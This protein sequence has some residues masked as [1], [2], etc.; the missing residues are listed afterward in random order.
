MQDVIN[1]GL[2]GYGNAAKVFHAPVIQAVQGLSLKKVVERRKKESSERY[3]WVDVVGDVTTLLLDESIELV[4]IATPNNTHFELARQALLS[5]KHVVVD[6][7]LTIT[8]EQAHQLIGLARQQKRV[9]SVF[10]NRRWDGDF[11]TVNKLIK[12][13]LLGRLV[14]FESH[15]DR[16]RNYRKP[17]WREDEGEGTGILYDLGPH[18]IDQAQTLFGLPEMVTADIRIQRDSAKVADYFEL[19]L[20]YNNLKAT[21]KAGMLVREPNKRFILHGTEGSYVKYGLDPQE[22]ALKQGLLPSSPNWGMER[23]E[24]WGKLNTNLNG[25]HFDGPLE[26]LP[27]SYQDYYRNIAD[28]IRGR[29]ELIVKPLQALNTIR[30]IE[31]ALLSNEEKR[32]VKYNGTK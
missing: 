15:F 10:Q 20:H 4:V 24:N 7:P 17:G 11:K 26:T 25:L 3:P 29:E 28:V 14:E 19:I 13:N 16:F 21:L 6:K 18:L 23:R 27:G 31:H 12:G 30:I 1:T 5:N 32:T 8:S 9:L 2:I 22:N